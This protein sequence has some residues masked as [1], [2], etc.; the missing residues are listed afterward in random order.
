MLER[1]SNDV[2]YCNGVFFSMSVTVMVSIT[3]MASITVMMQNACLPNLPKVI[4]AITD[5]WMD[6]ES[7]GFHSFCV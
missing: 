4:P 6:G 7:I 1:Y 3:V 2:H 5:V